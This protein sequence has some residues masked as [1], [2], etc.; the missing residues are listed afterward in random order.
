MHLSWF[1]LSESWQ[2]SKR[3][4]E[5]HSLW[6]SNALLKVRNLSWIFLLCAWAVSLEAL[7]TVY[8]PSTEVYSCWLQEAHSGDL[9]LALVKMCSLSQAGKG[10]VTAM[11]HNPRKGN[12]ENNTKLFFPHYPH[13]PTKVAMNAKQIQKHIWGGGGPQVPPSQDGLCCS[14]PSAVWRD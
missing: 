2:G 7:L 5:I 6:L 11:L 8:I 10:N 1:S 4:S 13:K 3:S 14:L 12:K 9:G